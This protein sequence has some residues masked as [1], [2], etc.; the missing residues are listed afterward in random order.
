MLKK[1]KEIAEGEHGG[2]LCEMQKFATFLWQ[3]MC[4]HT[5]GKKFFRQNVLNRR[6][7]IAMSV[8]ATIMWV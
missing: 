6:R 8:K 7:V 3:K 5:C 2:I 1:Q 4:W